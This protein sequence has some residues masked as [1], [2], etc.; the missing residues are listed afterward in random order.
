[1]TEP[2]GTASSVPFSV[3][4]HIALNET[5]ALES[6]TDTTNGLLFARMFHETV[7]YAVDVQRWFTWNGH[8][9]EQDSPQH[10]KV[11]ALTQ[12]VIRFRRERALLSSEEDREAL[13]KA[14]ASLESV[15]KR[16]AM[17]DV[18]RTDPRVQVE[19]LA[20]DDAEA[21][22]VFTNGTINLDTGEL[23]TSQPS[24][25]NSRACAVDY[26]A[27]AR[28]DELDR[29][30]S[31]FIPDK[32]AQDF[33]FRLLG[34]TLRRGNSLRILPIFW[35]GTTSG[36][37]QLFGA[38]HNALG[39]YICTI[40]PSVF[41]GNLDDKP[42]PDLVRAMLTRLAYATEGSK[43]W[44]LHA[45]QI[46]RLAGKDVLPYRDLYNG[47]LNV[48]PRF[49]PYIVAN[50]FPRITGKDKA[51][52]NRIIAVHFDRSLAPG[53]EDPTIRERFVSDPQVHRALLARI[54]K[55][56]KTGIKRDMSDAPKIYLEATLNAR[57]GMGHVDEFIEWAREEDYLLPAVE[58]LAMSACAKAKDLHDLY[59]YW[60]KK[61]ADKTD[62]LDG[63]GITRFGKVLREEKG[64]KTAVSAGVR[65]TEWR[66]SDTV[67]IW[68]KL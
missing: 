59:T 19:E 14:I 47:T 1:M 3:H 60:L 10:L 25:M 64:W 21:D 57:A 27:D 29:F 32:D 41:R 43:D 6:I 68:S 31:T 9:W 34:A 56:A 15:R 36:K 58:G 62:K 26:D 22:L 50:E 24:D 28:S 52:E 13:L 11:F 46:K 20:F 54:V 42:R 65:W 5:E 51:T 7:R 63:I 30:L 39:S 53:E 33:I 48:E 17:L 2:E 44:A 18:A 45:D 55:G 35:G 66:L 49:T 38:L 23:R 12:A 61:Y 40:G 4:D 67:P 16:H 8:F 37:S